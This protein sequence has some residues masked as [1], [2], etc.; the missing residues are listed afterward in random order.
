MHYDYNMA[1]WQTLYEKDFNPH[2]FLYHYTNITKAFKILYG[3]Q[4]KFSKLSYMNDTLESKPK[5]FWSNQLDSYLLQT[6]T[7]HFSYVN[8]NYLQLLCMSRD[9]TEEVTTTN[10]HTY[11]SDY[12]GRGFALPRMWAQYADN[13]N[14]VCFIFDKAK[15]CSLVNE[16]IGEGLIHMGE[17]DYCTQFQPPKANIKAVVDHL[18]RVSKGSNLF[19]NINEISFLK[20]YKDFSK[21]NYFSKLSDWSGEREYR[22]LAYGDD[23]YY[24]SNIFESIVGLV[25]GEAIDNAH[26][27]IIE[28]FCDKKFE[29]MKISFDCNGCNL[30]PIYS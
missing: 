22:F 28:H 30:N 23:D 20:Q 4:L 1:V 18:R 3:K 24:I 12:S 26:L 7:S 25:V 29:I 8:N 2:Q 11:F 17:V 16:E 5:F 10:E 14:G 15:L 19:R 27:N 6:L 9:S 21:Y 13:N